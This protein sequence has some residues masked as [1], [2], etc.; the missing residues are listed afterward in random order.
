[1]VPSFLT[2]FVQ[3]FKDFEVLGSICVDYSSSIHQSNE[4]KA[5]NYIP[6]EHN[7]KVIP[8]RSA[9]RF[10]RSTAICNVTS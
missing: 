2:P 3:S 7:N 6:M 8:Q 9:L 10:V 4:L 5:H 1:M